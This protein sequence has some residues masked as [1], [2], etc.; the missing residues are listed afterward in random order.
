M[1][2]TCLYAQ[3]EIRNLFELYKGLKKKL[4]AF[5]VIDSSEGDQER[6]LQALTAEEE[7]FV[8]ALNANLASLVGAVIRAWP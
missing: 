4:K 7:H 1:S 3:P 6:K 8:S 5:P 2:T